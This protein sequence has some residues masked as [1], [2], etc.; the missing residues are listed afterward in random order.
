MPVPSGAFMPVFILGEGFLVFNG[1]F[2][3]FLSLDDLE[4]DVH[5]YFNIIHHYQVLS[6]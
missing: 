2:V 1:L 3:L 5:Q 6:S 4:N